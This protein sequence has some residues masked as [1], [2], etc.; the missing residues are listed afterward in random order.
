MWWNMSVFMQQHKGCVM[1]RPT[2]CKQRCTDT[3][4]LHPQTLVSL[5]TWHAPE[6]AQGASGPV[7]ACSQ[8]AE[9]A[10]KACQ[11]RGIACS[12]ILREK[13]PLVVKTP[14]LG[15]NRADPAAS[16]AAPPQP[17]AQPQPQP[18]RGAA[19][20]PPGLEAVPSVAR[21]LGFAGRA[22]LHS[23]SAHGH[24]QECRLSWMKKSSR[25]LPVQECWLHASPD[26]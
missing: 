6:Q 3:E 9:A 7:A 1:I 26:A 2:Q 11:Q 8:R 17:A 5:R 15:A 19:A 18:A 14:P 21:T 13:V 22:M 4:R 10:A 20:A 25:A 12:A 24:V 23:A 16:S